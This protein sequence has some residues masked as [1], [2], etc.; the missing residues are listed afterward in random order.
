MLRYTPKRKRELFDRIARAFKEEAI[1][2]MEAHGISAEEFDE[3]SVLV[4]LDGTKALRATRV[5]DYRRAA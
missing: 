2:I 5:Q 3:W 1:Q 4:G